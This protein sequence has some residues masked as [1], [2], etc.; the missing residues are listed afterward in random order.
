MPCPKIS[1][2]QHSLLDEPFSN[3]DAKLR[4][5]TR[6]WFQALQRRLNLTTVFV[7]HDQDE[8]LSMSDRI[9]VMDSAGIAQEGTQEEVYRNPSTPFGS[10]FVGQC[11]LIDAVVEKLGNGCLVALGSEVTFSVEIDPAPFAAGAH[12]TLVLRPVDIHVGSLSMR[13]GRG[14]FVS[15]DAGVELLLR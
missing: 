13:N 5:R 10:D 3:F 7:T 6:V 11:N 4:E 15:R 1:F 9:L 8:A 14:E 2:L 12:V